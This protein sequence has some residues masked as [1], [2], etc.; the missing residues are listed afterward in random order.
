M[1]VSV[2]GMMQ[3]PGPPQLVPGMMR[4]GPGI[5]IGHHMLGGNM[6]MM[7]PPHMGIHPGE[8]IF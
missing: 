2:A 8:F 7:R 5:P 1:P 3:V 6:G 4:Q